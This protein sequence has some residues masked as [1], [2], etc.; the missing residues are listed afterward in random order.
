MRYMIPERFW[1]KG[2]PFDIYD[3]NRRPI[4]CVR[5]AEFS[6]EHHW[7]V[8]DLERHPLAYTDQ[9]TMMS[10]VKYVIFREQQPWITIAGSAFDSRISALDLEGPNPYQLAGRFWQLDYSIQ[11]PNHTLATVGQHPW[12]HARMISVETNDEDDLSV[13]QIAMT[14]EQILHG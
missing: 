11:G 8:E 1:E 7:T 2:S 10:R 12:A 14:I 4:M 5:D 9:E 13:L 6:W 3:E